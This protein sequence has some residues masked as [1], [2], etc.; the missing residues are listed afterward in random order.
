MSVDVTITSGYRDPSYFDDLFQS[1]RYPYI[2][3]PPLS[4]AIPAH[5]QLDGLQ[6]GA[7]SQYYHF[8]STEHNK[9]SVWLSQ[10]SMDGGATQ[11]ENITLYGNIY[12]NNA[13]ESSGGH[14]QRYI[15]WGDTGDVDTYI[16]EYEDDVLRVVCNN[17]LVMT[18][19]SADVLISVDLEV[20]GSVEI[21]GNFFFTGGVAV[22]TIEVNLTEDDT[23]LPT[24]GAVFDAIA[25]AVAAED[26]WDI[27]SAGVISPANSGDDLE[28]RGDDG[29]ADLTIGTWG[30][31]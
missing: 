10:M 9:L 5:N 16:H 14:D 25:A 13:G 2:Q 29:V 20:S 31:T 28:F 4:S 19:D 22:D 11:I 30:Y 12:F 24:S 6:G 18:L 26:I 7:A 21:T 3:A 1:S 27:S 23:H 15:Y 8:D 17:G